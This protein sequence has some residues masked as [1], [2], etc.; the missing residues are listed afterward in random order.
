MEWRYEKGALLLLVVVVL[1]YA[2]DMGLN[3]TNANGTKRLPS[4]LQQSTE[5][6]NIFRER[7]LLP[8]SIKFTKSLCCKRIIGQLIQYNYT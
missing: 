7:E 1:L 5:Q 8:I 6:I 2:I 4:C 3:A